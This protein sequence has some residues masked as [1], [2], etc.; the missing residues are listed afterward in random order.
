V[1]VCVC[2][3]F[4]LSCNWVLKIR[5]H[6]NLCVSFLELEFGNEKPPAAACKALLGKKIPHKINDRIINIRILCF[7]ISLTG[8]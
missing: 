4:D 8:I 5:V 6:N 3:C 7:G 2:V 1:C